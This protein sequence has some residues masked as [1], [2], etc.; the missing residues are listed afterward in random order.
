MGD[1]ISL[2][3]HRHDAQ[4]AVAP[5]HSCS[6][7][8]PPPAPA[9]DQQIDPVCGMA[10]TASIEKLRDHFDGND[11]FFCGPR[12][13]DKFRAEPARYAVTGEKKGGETSTSSDVIYTCPMH[14]QVRQV[15]PGSCPICGMALEP[16]ES[17]VDTGANPELVDMR[18]RFWVGVPLALVVF[19]LAMGHDVPGLA[20][21]ADAPWSAWIQF[22]LS[23]PVV[24][25]CG[26]PFLVRGVE[27]VG[28]RKLN[29]FTL[30]ALG[31]G[32]AYLY[33]LVALLVPQAFPANLRDMHGRIGIYF[34]ASAVI[35]VLVLLGQVLELQ[36]RE[37]T[38]GAIR[39]L[40]KLAPK[41]AHRVTA[42]GVESDVALEDTHVGDRLRVRP[43][44][45]VPVD[46]VLESGASGVDESMLTG[47]SMPVEKIVGARVVGGSINGTGAFVMRADKVGKDTLLAQIVTLVSA[48][49][50]S[51]AP[52][53]RLADQVA[54]WFVPAVIAVAVA[55]FA[56]WLAWG[57]APTLA[58]ALVAAVTVLIIACPC[59]LGLATPM[60]IMVAVGRGAQEG[61]LVKNAA[62]LERLEKVDTLVIDK[63]GTLTE[64]RPQV[65]GV[66]PSPGVEQDMLLSVAQGL[67]RSSEHPLAQA[68]RS[69][70]SGHP[71][72]PAVITD[73]ASITGE[74]VRGYLGG[75][76]VA[77]GNKKL[78]ESAGIDLSSIAVE[79]DRLRDEGATVMFVS[80]GKALLGLVAVADPVKASTPAAL[81]A[82]RATGLKIV[83]VTGDNRRTA[84]TIAR[85]LG[86]K[87]IEA[88]VL[89][90]QKGEIVKRLQAG[91]AVVAMAGDGVNDAPALA[92]ADVGIAMGTGTDVA[93]E[94]AGITLVKGDLIGIVRARQLSHAAMR[95]IRQ[96]LVLA[97]VYNALGIPIAAG[98]LYP[99]FGLLLSPMVAAAAMSLSSVSVIGNALRLRV[100]TL[101]A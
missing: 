39:A 9:G 72:A 25:W 67:E 59:A 23:T 24:L 84:D 73:F 95:N 42:D 68:I 76:P 21:I 80:R 44:E 41:V 81:H 5:R 66:H 83:M 3:P 52:I 85:Q 91:G 53:Q 45:R 20:T 28:R 51:Q 7:N 87:D 89:P 27:S 47:E 77:L 1:T 34:E 19:V 50:R 100:V 101:S 29:M 22:A 30:I 61:V 82:L 78:L 15:G 33:S 32:A 4:A 97:F 55:A 60:S 96:N 56:A 6:G 10:V 13:L 36:A 35:I 18:R 64:G 62:A 57:P 37:R 38:G 48:A 86:I 58:H 43:G 65:T 70:S 2:E 98:V 16:V 90:A 12:C 99:M 94:S 14:P 93:I 46:G 17:T 92:S 75:E 31:V 69:F 49:Q 8:H 54:A 11:Y 40:L 26:W 79:A 63:T 74:G 88:E 71:V